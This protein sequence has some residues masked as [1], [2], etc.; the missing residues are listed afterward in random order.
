MA[1]IQLLG[2][3]L[4]DVLYA[5]EPGKVYLLTFPKIFIENGN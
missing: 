4:L 5:E 1:I 2:Y 3:G